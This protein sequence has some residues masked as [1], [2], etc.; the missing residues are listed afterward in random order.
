MIRWIRFSLGLLVAVML[1]VFFTLYFMFGVGIYKPSGTQSSLFIRGGNLFRGVDATV[2]ENPGIQV[3]DGRIVCLG[4]LCE[5]LPDS[6]VIDATGLSIV[7]GLIELHGHF[8][9]ITADNA[10]M[11]LTRLGWNMVRMR[12]DVRKRLHEHGV[13]SFRSVGDPRDF[14][15]EL[16]AYLQRGDIAG[17][18]IF[19]AGPIFTAPGGHP[20]P[21][22]R[23]PNPSG[24]GG[25]M[26]FQSDDPEAIRAEVALLAE[27][28]ADGIKAVF[29][30]ALS[31]SGTTLLPTLSEE[32]LRALID[33]A[34]AHDMWV[35]VHVGPLDEIRKA[36][37]AGAD[38]I[39]HGVRAGNL[40][41][42][43][44]LQ[45]LVENEVVYVPTLGRE[46][47]G[48]LNIP[49]LYEAGVVI[50]VGTDTNNPAMR[51]GDS[52]HLE[53]QALVDAGMP[54]AEVLLAATRNGAKALGM[55]DVL[56][57]LQAGYLADLL[58]VQ[59]APWNDIAELRNIRMVIQNG[60]VVVDQEG[61]SP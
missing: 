13:T 39:E 35:A 57:T 40:V 28:G 30:G 45:L 38:T 41:D 25:N 18:R 58:L 9:A 19:A 17:P 23:D 4:S 34:H 1:A 14:M 59:G 61:L 31:E 48:Y 3:V 54:D 15:I 36:I 44:T 47:M 46:P 8:A 5:P 20:A 10:D 21:G 2:E 24:F 51:Y 22:G 29:H 55:E 42:A 43:E 50:G 37:Q 6:R 49:A 11:N 16:K 27:Q 12:P 7:P 60:L 52:Y 33:E 26:A 32:S 56:G 53:L